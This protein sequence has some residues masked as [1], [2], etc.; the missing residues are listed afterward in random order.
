MTGFAFTEM[1]VN[2][3]NLFSNHDKEKAEDLFDI[4]LPL[5]RHEQ[6][7]GIG[8][9]LR[10]F[11]LQHRGIIKSLNVRSP[12]P[13][14]TEDDIKEMNYLLKRL[15]SKLTEKGLPIPKGID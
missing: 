13:V 11:V 12:G 4:Y 5:I 9:A 2:L 1:L 7:F 15:H 6:Q 8:L 14:L 3:H 10:K